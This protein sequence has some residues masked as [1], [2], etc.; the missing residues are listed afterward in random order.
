MRFLFTIFDDC[1]LY[2]TGNNLYRIM[3]WKLS[4]L[5]CSRNNSITQTY[6]HYLKITNL[7]FNWLKFEC[8]S[9]RSRFSEGTK[10]TLYSSKM[11]NIKAPFYWIY[12]Q[13]YD[14]NL[15]MLEE[16]D[17]DDNEPKD[18]V[19]VLKHQK[20]TTWLYIFLLISINYMLDFS[21]CKHFFF[22]LF[23]FSIILYSF[24]H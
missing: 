2:W 9:F 7:S 23:C 15:F 4:F 1:T 24:L 5:L 21:F 16:D 14:Y 18:P 11:V 8:E 10:R 3:S 13:G 12:R 22:F 6:L 17:Y 20:L 19:I